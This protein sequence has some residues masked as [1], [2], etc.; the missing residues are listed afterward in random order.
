MLFKTRWLLLP[1]VLLCLLV[2]AAAHVGL[3]QEGTDDVDNF[4]LNVSVP[5]L[6][7]NAPAN[8]AE[9][10]DFASQ[11]LGDA[12]DMSNVQ[13]LY[14]HSSP[15]CEF[16]RTFENISTTNGEW[17]GTSKVQ[18]KGDGT[19]GSDSPS[20]WLLFPG[21]KGTVF[22]GRDGMAGHAIDTTKYSK[23]TVRMYIGNV[24]K[25]PSDP[26]P[27]DTIRL[28][29]T[30]GDLKD[31]SNGR[32]ATSN[33]IAP[34]Q[35][36]HTY[37]INLNT[38]GVQN[39]GTCSKPIAGWTGNITGLRILPIADRNNVE[40]KVDWARLT[41]APVTNPVT[42]AD[43]SLA[44]KTISLWVDNDTNAGNGFV[45]QVAVDQDAGAGTYNLDSSHLPPGDYYVYG[46]LGADYAGLTLADPWDM[47][48]SSDVPAFGGITIS[49]NG[50]TLNG[51]TTQ[52]G[53][54]INLNVH[55]I[56][57]IDP[58]KF[59][60]LTFRQNTTESN[61]NY[62]VHW[63]DSDDTWHTGDVGN[64]SL[65][66]GTQIY[67]IDLSVFANWNNGKAKKSF[68]LLP[69][70]QP[71]QQFQLDWVSLTTGSQPT[72]ESDL[73]AQIGYSSL[74]RVNQAPVLDFTQPSMRSGVDYAS[75]SLGNLWDFDS[76]ADVASTLNLIKQ[77]Y[78]GG[79]FKSE[80][81][82]V[83]QKCS[84]DPLTAPWGE[85]N[86][87]VKMGKK[88]D[89]SRFRYITFRMQLDS[90][91]DVGWGWVTRIFFL[92]KGYR[93]AQFL[94][95]GDHAVGND[96]I[97]FEG[98]NDYTIDYGL[99]KAQKPDLYDD[100]VESYSE[101]TTIT[102]SFFRFDPHEIPNGI[103]RTF[104][105]DSIEIRAKDVADASFNIKWTQQNAESE[106]TTVTLYYESITAR[107]GAA[108]PVK[109][110]DVTNAISYT[111]DTSVV[112]EGEYRI[113]GVVTDGVNSSEWW[114][115]SPLIIDRTP[116]INFVG[117]DP[118]VKVNEG[119]RR[120]WQMDSSTELDG[121]D[122]TLKNWSISGGHLQGT[123]GGGAGQ[124]WVALN[125]GR[126]TID[127]AVYSKLIVRQSTEW[128]RKTLSQFALQFRDADNGTDIGQWH[129]CNSV[130]DQK[131]AMNLEEGWKIYTFDLTKCADWQNGRNK[132]QIR[133]MPA[134][135]ANYG[136]EIDWLKF[137]QPNSATHTIQWQN[138]TA[139]AR[140]VDAEKL[141]VALYYDVNN[142]G[143]DGELIASGLP[144]T[145]SYPWDTSYLDHRTFYIYA[146]VYNHVSP[147]SNK[148]SPT[149]VQIGSDLDKHLFLPEIVR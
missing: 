13:D 104:E 95:D 124:S 108:T 148:Y 143:A 12:W 63:Q 126:V 56:N 93:H 96:I 53:G 8:V 27:W 3:A 122:T 72:Q 48:Q 89:T 24:Q 141:E 84:D 7:I 68:R 65:Q 91:Q 67:S 45:D 52:G 139:S 32:C 145:G 98:W 120:S 134:I 137:Y 125:L 130:D 118:L 61:K 41:G 73:S 131:K 110:A 106:S 28:Q 33:T 20:F 112:A 107:G 70:V 11:N 109:I 121:G 129:T 136:V 9:G 119:T 111:W 38:I 116:K 82:L 55:S 58:T 142:S 144:A 36:W 100:E 5:A 132:N 30:D 90:A 87:N 57:Y 25:P 103:P 21:Y 79:I 114:S 88:I 149:A 128:D 10:A 44:G 4:P 62:S 47:Q 34:V 77:V 115:E 29:W 2:L 81:A 140:S 60:R 102:P 78:E 54:F 133:Y 59:T 138:A 66:A 50:G 14:L 85:P 123:T 74:M 64:R 94:P 147:P 127:P 49:F 1:L 83:Q 39:Q 46:A 71:S 75:E 99:T 26:Q 51:T 17:S 146:E 80:G 117:S 35:G 135:L 69:V 16:P 113:K 23:L 42:W 43:G 92:D 19:G 76:S 97:I 31:F 101:W 6:T 40:V 37:E 22:M 18:S 15:Y 105:L 86:V